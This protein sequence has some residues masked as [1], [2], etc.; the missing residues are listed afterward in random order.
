LNLLIWKDFRK[1]G[2]SIPFPQRDVY[3]KEFSGSSSAP[4]ADSEPAT[5]SMS[6]KRAK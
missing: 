5:G 3:I 6:P 4:V 1:A 2:I